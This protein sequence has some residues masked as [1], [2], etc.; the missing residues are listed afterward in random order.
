LRQDRGRGFVEAITARQSS[1]DVRFNS[2]RANPAERVFAHAA[3]PE[4]DE[5]LL[6]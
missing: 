4:A 3:G 1:R 6:L 2:S 5:C